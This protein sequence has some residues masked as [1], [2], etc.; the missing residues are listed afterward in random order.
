MSVRRITMAR[1]SHHTSA[2]DLLVQGTYALRHALDRLTH[3][4][5]AGWE[6]QEGEQVFEK[7]L[8]VAADIARKSDAEF[9]VGR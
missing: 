4:R 9:V 3:Q 2:A 6:S 8:S 5:G 7:P 1:M